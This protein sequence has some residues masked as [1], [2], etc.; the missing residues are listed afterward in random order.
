[1]T[2]EVKVT[3]A[4]REAASAAYYDCF[5]TPPN[6]LWMAKMENGG[7]D[8]D[9]VVQAFAKHRLAERERIVALAR[10]QSEKGADRAI[11]YEQGSKSRIGLGAGSLALARFA[12]LIER[13]H[14]GEGR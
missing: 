14:E 11:K 4:D 5:E 6:A 2:T 9:P 3:Q 1:M 7:H 10:E 13:G 8:D 12:D